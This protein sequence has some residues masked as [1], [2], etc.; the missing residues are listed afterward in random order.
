MGAELLNAAWH[1]PLQL[2]DE[3][4]LVAA[5]MANTSVYGIAF[6]EGGLTPEDLHQPDLRIIVEVIG[7]ILAD[8]AVGEFVD[9]SGTLIPSSFYP[10]VAKRTT[11]GKRPSSSTMTSAVRACAST[12]GFKTSTTAFSTPSE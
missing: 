3:W 7:E 12:S 2:D 10:E 11:N 5:I 8:G 4:S 6:E 1:Q 9:E